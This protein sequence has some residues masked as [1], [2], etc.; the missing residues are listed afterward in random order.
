MWQEI[1]HRTFQNRTSEAAFLLHVQIWHGL[2]KL[3]EM[4]KESL[5]ETW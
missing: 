1:L 4:D 5:C 2:S 3:D